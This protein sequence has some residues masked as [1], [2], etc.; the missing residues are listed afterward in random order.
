MLPGICI[1]DFRPGSDFDTYGKFTGPKKHH[2]PYRNSK[3]QRSN[4]RLRKIR[5]ALHDGQL[6][7]YS[8]YTKDDNCVF[9]ASHTQCSRYDITVKILQN[10]SGQDEM[11][12]YPN[13]MQFQPRFHLK[14]RITQ[15]GILLL[16]ILIPTLGLF[17][18]DLVTASFFINGLQVE[19]TNY[20]FLVG[21]VSAVFTA[22]I[23]TYLTVGSVFCGWACPQNLFSEM[24]DGLTHKLLGKRAHVRIDGPGMIVA[25]SKNKSANWLILGIS[26]AAAS[27]VLAFFFLMFFYSRSD[28][29]NFLTGATDRQ[30]GMIVM[31]GITTFFI[32]IDI[33]TVRYLYCD[34]IC[35]YRVWL[36][37][38]RSR[39]ALHVSYDASRSASCEKCNY[40]AA[41]CITDIQPTN[42]RITD[43]CVDCGECIDACDRLHAKSG[44]HGLLSFKVGESGTDMTWRKMLGKAFSGSRWLLGA[45]FLLGCI[46][47]VSGVE[48]ASQKIADK[49][50]QLL[51]NQ[52]IQKISHICNRQCAALQATCN[53]NS[54]KNKDFSGCYRASACMCACTLQQDPA[55][56][57]ADSLRQCVRNGEAHAQELK[58]LKLR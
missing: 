41:S 19:W 56:P 51:E 6:Y 9:A 46:L 10:T 28:M 18:I 26:F 7:R 25:A 40:C 4:P 36:R 16:I 45:F 14:R 5:Y 33:A 31:Y 24:A 43:T 17:R 58:G 3:L 22:L 47:M 35:L 39:D 57:S 32:F 30:P 54:V 34:Y 29:W 44:K 55:S 12:K 23:I 20:Y 52:K 21:L 8:S 53:G 15:L 50:K 13:T 27:A 37:F 1:F 11:E 42:I 2:K 38:F 49:Q 48:I